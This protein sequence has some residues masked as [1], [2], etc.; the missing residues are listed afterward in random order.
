MASTDSEYWAHVLTIVPILGAVV[1]TLVYFIRL[2]SRWLGTASLAVD[3]ALMGIGVLLS[4]GATV[5]V[6][7]SEYLLL[8]SLFSC[9]KRRRNE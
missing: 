9:R 4:Y 1:A 3:D 2:Y 8:S 6:V 5:F 7:Y